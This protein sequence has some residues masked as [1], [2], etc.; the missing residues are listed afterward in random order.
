MIEK[1][2]KDTCENTLEIIPQAA[3]LNSEWLVQLSKSHQ[4]QKVLHPHNYWPL[5]KVISEKKY[6]EN[7]QLIFKASF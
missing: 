7:T 2:V 6:S 5:I 4:R 1:D 3:C